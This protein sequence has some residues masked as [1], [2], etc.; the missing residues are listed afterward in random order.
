MACE[1]L[2][3]FNSFKGNNFLSELNNHA[4]FLPLMKY[5]LESLLNITALDWV[6]SVHRDFPINRNVHIL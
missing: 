2:T 4:K 5:F 1:I 3:T 6:T